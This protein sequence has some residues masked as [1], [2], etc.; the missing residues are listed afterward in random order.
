MK[1][2][3]VFF[4][5]V[6]DPGMLQRVEFY[7]QDIRILK[8][9]GCDLHIVTRPTELRPADLY[10]VWWWT[11]AVPPILMAHLTNRPA[12]VTGTFDYWLYLKRPRWQQWLLRGALKHASSNI[13]VSELER[14]Q[15]PARLTV[16]DPC[17]SPHIV[18]T[19]V[20]CPGGLREPN[21]VFT[22][23]WTGRLNSWRKCIPEIL[24][25]AAK[26]LGSDPALRFLIAGEQGSH[27]PALM[28]QARELGIADRLSFLGTISRAEKIRLFQSCTV[29]LQPSRFEGFGLAI[30]EAMSCGAPVVTSPAGAVPEVVGDSAVLVDGTSPAAI[31]EGVRN[32]LADSGLR[33]ELGA[34]GRWRAQTLFNYRRRKRELGAILERTLRRL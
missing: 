11:W 12:L 15:V 19:E 26:L 9:L 10:F 25:A 3:V 20:Y 27:Y 18:D 16:R 21:L 13:F 7:A 30:L 17:Y 14:R 1:R 29:Y 33:A 8:D 34:A 24:R 32:L 22:I 6:P 2:P 23:A 5:K 31:A 28:A 4:A